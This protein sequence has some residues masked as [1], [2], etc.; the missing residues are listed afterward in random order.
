MGQI[1]SYLYIKGNAMNWVTLLG[2][3]SK[4]VGA[5][6]NKAIASAAVAVI[7]YSVGHGNPLGDVSNI[8]SAVAVAISTIISGF[9]ATQGI[10]IPAINAD[11]TNGVRVVNST[12]ASPSVNGPL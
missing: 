5:L 11:M 7:A 3:F 12:S 9:A 4:P 10:Q 2:I 8:V 1:G 6:L